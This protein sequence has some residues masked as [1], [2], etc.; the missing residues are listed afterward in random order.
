MALP[1]L[2][3]AVAVA[4]AEASDN[5]NQ[6]CTCK[7]ILVGSSFFHARGLCSGRHGRDQAPILLNRSTQL[8]PYF[9]PSAFFKSNFVHGTSPITLI[10]LSLEYA[11]IVPSH[12]ASK[13]PARWLGV[14][15]LLTRTG[16]SV[17]IIVLRPSKYHFSKHYK[18]TT[19]CPLPT[20]DLT[21]KLATCV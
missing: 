16:L 8:F 12:P 3:T 17:S 7:G 9:S 18:H 15:R 21:G 2:L 14:F 4:A 11:M 20:M 13:G 1:N 10:G 6:T 19:L 5:R